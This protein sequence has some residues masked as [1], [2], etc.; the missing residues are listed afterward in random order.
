[1]GTVLSFITNSRFFVVDIFAAEGDAGQELVGILS[2]S[3]NAMMFV[4]GIGT[5]RLRGKEALLC[6]QPL[7]PWLSKD[8]LSSSMQLKRAVNLKK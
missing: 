6:L 3:N 7:I 1:M 4:E 5:V 8:D 2:Q